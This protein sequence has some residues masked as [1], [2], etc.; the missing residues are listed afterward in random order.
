MLDLLGAVRI[1]EI[2]DGCLGKRIGRAVAERVE[3]VSL[4]LGRAAVRRGD[5][6]GDGTRRGREGAGVVKELSGDGPLGALGEGNEMRLGA[7]ASG[8]T[9]SREGG[10]GSHEADE[11]TTGKTASILAAGG[12]IRELAGE[13]FVELGAVLELSLGSP[14]GWLR[15]TR[16]VLENLFHRWQPPQLTGGLTFQ[17]FLNWSPISRCAEADAGCQFM[18]K[19]SEGGRRKFSGARWQSRHH[20]MLS[21]SAS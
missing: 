4:D 18:L 17:S 10:G 14:E 8:Q 9:D 13:R 11:I 1:V 21:D 3:R 6:D 16:G 20:F 12:G 15:V 2:E 7:A 5:D 19:T